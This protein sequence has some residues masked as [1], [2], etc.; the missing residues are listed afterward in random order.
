MSYIGF[1]TV[2]ERWKPEG[3]VGYWLFR[4][5]TQSLNDTA[6]PKQSKGERKF[7][8]KIVLQNGAMRNNF[9][10]LL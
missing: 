4:K 9:C 8:K 1:S 3:K 10:I 7:E 5:D 6:T 2:K